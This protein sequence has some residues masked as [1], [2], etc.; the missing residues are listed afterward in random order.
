MLKLEQP[1]S[2]SSS[3]NA[4]AAVQAGKQQ[5]VDLQLGEL[6]L[7]VQAGLA[8]AVRGAAATGD[9]I[10]V[11]LLVGTTHEGDTQNMQFLW[12]YALYCSRLCVQQL[13]TGV[14]ALETRQQ[15]Q[16]PSRRHCYGDAVHN[17]QQLQMCACCK[18]SMLSACSTFGAGGSRRKRRH[19]WHPQPTG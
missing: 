11:R 15:K 3:S 1:G 12:Q 2:S 14:T 17:Q 10:Q 9:N 13:L 8:K 6:L 5:P 7:D 16:K 4:A 19:A 18:G